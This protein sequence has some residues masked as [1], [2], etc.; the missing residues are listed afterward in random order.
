MPA[1]RKH[2][3]IIVC[4]I[5]LAAAIFRLT[6]LNWDQNQ[7]LH[8]DE[9]FL[10]LVSL[11]IKLPASVKEYLDPDSSPLNPRNHEYNFFVYGL[12]PIILNKLIALSIHTDTYTALTLQGR[13]LSAASDLATVLLIFSFAKEA[14]NSLF[15]KQ[16]TKVGLAAALTYGLMVTPIQLSH[17]FTVDTFL[18]L[19]SFAS[20]VA[21]FQ[22]SRT[23]KKRYLVASGLCLGLAL[24]SKLTAIYYLP[25][26]ISLLWIDQDAWKGIRQIQARKLTNWIRNVLILLL[27]GYITLRLA[28]PYLFASGNMLQPA[29]SKDFIANITQL[30]SWEGPDVMFPPSI[31]WIPTKPIVFSAKNIM[32]LGV[33]PVATILMLIGLYQA[34]KTKS[35]VHIISI[36]WMIAVFCYQ[37]SQ[38]AKPL[39]Y[40]V[41]IYP[42]MAVYAGIGFTFLVNKVK[43]KHRIAAVSLATLALLIW[44][45]MFLSIYLRPHTRITASRWMY[46]HLEPNAHL[47]LEHWDDP[48]PLRFPDES[49]ISL[50]G[51]Q[52]PIFDP[53]TDTKWAQMNNIFSQSDYYVLTSNR[54]WGSIPKVPERYP[55]MSTFYEDLL[56][57]RGGFVKIAEFTSYPS[58]T[59]LGIPLTLKD[60]WADETFTVYDHPKVMI[61]KKASATPEK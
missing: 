6:G 30:K 60:D 59:Y 8:P 38:F 32:L 7:H 19:F 21:V 1:I 16:S 25:L 43:R 50:M 20:L 48:L 56:A 5:L 22:Y 57:G 10:T 51:T 41:S 27:C 26:V 18:S 15:G 34:L 3:T 54:G 13:F 9:R 52:L 2:T 36:G 4:L 47:A 44:P 24:A 17:F 61:F 35:P 28:D 33:S 31:Q 55:R 12:F 23:K 53:D 40:F 14:T 39:R 11:D 37:A 42:L 45:A 58:L 46:D 29:I 49:T